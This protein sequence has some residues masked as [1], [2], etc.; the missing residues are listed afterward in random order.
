MA[1]EAA[2]LSVTCPSDH[3][4]SLV[5]H[6]GGCRGGLVVLHGGRSSSLQA[7]ESKPRS[8]LEMI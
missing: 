1:A 3:T 7:R 4:S 8:P 5:G 2:T 6:P